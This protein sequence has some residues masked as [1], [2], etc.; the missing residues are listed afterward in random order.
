MISRCLECHSPILSSCRC[1]LNVVRC[2][3]CG[4]DGRNKTLELLED[5]GGYMGYMLKPQA[6]RCEVCGGIGR[7]GVQYKQLGG[8]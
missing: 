2:P 6:G 8:S 7:V 3:L 1:G 5:S 4:G